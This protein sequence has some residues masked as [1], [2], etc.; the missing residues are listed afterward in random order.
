MRRSLAQEVAVCLVAPVVFPVVF[1]A[2]LLDQLL[3][4][5]GCEAGKAVKTAG[6]KLKYQFK[7]RVALR[8]PVPPGAMD[9]LWEGGDGQIHRAPAVNLSL[10]A[11][12]FEAPGFD[13]VKIDTI[14]RHGFQKVL[15][16]KRCRIKRKKG[17][18][19]L[20]ILD[21]FMDNVDDRM[22]WIE[23]LTRIEEM[24]Q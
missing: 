15:R 12:L 19:V 5:G 9:I 1:I 7:R 11:A 4:G 8:I 10:H 22:E 2:V 17:N 6:E 21:E 23:I 14:E 3:C 18:M 13:A 16:V 20:A 24:A